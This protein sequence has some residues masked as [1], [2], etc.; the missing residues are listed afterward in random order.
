MKN[1]CGM[2]RKPQSGCSI[3]AG[4][5]SVARAERSKGRKQSVRSCGGGGDQG[6]TGV[7]GRWPGI[8][9]LEIRKGMSYLG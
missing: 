1:V 2:I 8:T 3:L 5:P 4:V 7:A 6:A 9:S